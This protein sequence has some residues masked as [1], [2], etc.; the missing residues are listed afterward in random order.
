SGSQFRPPP[1][2]DLSSTD[3]ATAF[4]EVKVV[5]AGDA[6]TSD[7]DGNGLPDRTADQREIAFFWRDAAGTS[8]AF[9]HWNEIAAAVSAREGLDLVQ[10]A[11][12]F[13]LLNLAEADAL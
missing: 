6:E 10:N 1:P 12:L 3:Y 5:G 13:A 7:R 11:R 8:Y 9:G 4:N 2:P